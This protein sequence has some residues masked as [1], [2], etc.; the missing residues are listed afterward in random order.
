MVQ[1]R[2]V[3]VQLMDTPSIHPEE[4]SIGRITQKRVLQDAR[5]RLDLGWE[6]DAQTG[7]HAVHD[8][9]CGNVNLE[10]VAAVHVKQMTRIQTGRYFDVNER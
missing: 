4:L 5:V 1:D 3:G 7:H 8:G 9:L 6:E 10:G 2:E